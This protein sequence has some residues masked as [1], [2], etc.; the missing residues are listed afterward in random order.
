MVLKDT[1]KNVILKVVMTLSLILLNILRKPQLFYHPRFYAEEGQSFF[2]AAYNDSF[3]HYLLSPM[4]GYYALYNVIATSLATFVPLEIAPLITTYQA[5]II[6]VATSVF[7]IWCN[8]PIL[9]SNSKRFITAISFPLLCPCQ[10]WLTTIGVQYWLCI[11]TVLIFL[12]NTT[13]DN[14]SAH[15]AKLLALIFTGLTGVLS[16][17]LTPIFMLKWI[18]TRSRRFL[19]YTFILGA[20]SIIQIFIFTHAWLKHDSGII[21]R[22]VAHSDSADIMYTN[23]LYF[24]AGFIYSN[25]IHQIPIINKIEKVISKCVEITLI[26]RAVTEIEAVMILGTIVIIFTIVSLVVEYFRSIDRMCILLSSAI[27]FMS[28][29]ILSVDS[30]GG[31]RYLFAPSA[32]LIIFLIASYDKY[33]LTPSHRLLLIS[34]ITFFIFIHIYDYVPSMDR[35]YNEKWPKWEEEVHLWQINSSHPLKIWPPPWEIV[36]RKPII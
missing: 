18:F 6:Q 27:I 1:Q 17:I 33:I 21:N 10:I 14:M 20:C 34:V 2:A 22:F 29:I 13:S 35:T 16:C 4:Y 9:D 36:L 11:I 7:V 30:S 3:L 8:I 25:H 23:I 24:F 19:H 12:E 26:K 31:P 15:V 5:L 28:S 32:M